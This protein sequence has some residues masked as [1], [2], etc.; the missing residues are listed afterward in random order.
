MAY[1]DENIQRTTL[2]EGSVK[3]SGTGYKA[4]LK[5]GEQAVVQR[6]AIKISDLVDLEEVIAWKDG[7]FKFN[8]SLESIMAKISRWYDVEIV[9]ENKPDPS[10]TFA[11]EISRYRDLS[12][13]LTIIEYTGKVKFTIEG[14][15]I[16]VEN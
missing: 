7:Y 14:R 10:Q 3:V 1:A 4:M 5:P 13:I 8:E 11:G 15:R 2:L 16:I 12:E 9:Y 6:N